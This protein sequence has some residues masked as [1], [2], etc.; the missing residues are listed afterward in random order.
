MTVRLQTQ[1]AEFIRFICQMVHLLNLRYMMVLREIL[2]LKESVV[3]KVKEE[4][5]LPMRTLQQI[6]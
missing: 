6:S 3:S 1:Q 5:L 2:E 4:K